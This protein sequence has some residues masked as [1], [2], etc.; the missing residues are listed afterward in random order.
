M[1]C[2]SESKKLEASGCNLPPNCNEIDPNTL[3]C[4][5]CLT[6]FKLTPQGN[7]ILP[8]I[9]KWAASSNCAQAFNSTHCAVCTG[10][11]RILTI[12]DTVNDN[13]YGVGECVDFTSLTCK[14]PGCELTL[15]R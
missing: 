2:S 5:Q 14:F 3:R 12:D 11:N 10:A 13:Q 15:R 7:C 9:G 1:Q 4:V 6:P 8:L